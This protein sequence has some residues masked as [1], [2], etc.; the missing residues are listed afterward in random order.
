M[1][2]DPSSDFFFH[3]TKII[4]AQKRLQ[5]IYFLDCEGNKKGDVS[6]FQ[7]QA[8]MINKL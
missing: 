5:G 1:G 2:C 4:Q 6:S 8:V 7:V 3:E